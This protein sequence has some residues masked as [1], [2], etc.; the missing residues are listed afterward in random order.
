MTEAEQLQMC[1]NC[2]KPASFCKGDCKGLTSARIH[3]RTTKEMDDL[4]R[5]FYPYCDMISELQEVTGIHKFQIR[6]RCKALGLD[7]TK[8]QRTKAGGEAR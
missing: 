2:D 5:R 6:E 4:I 3:R 1:L 8:L 7:M